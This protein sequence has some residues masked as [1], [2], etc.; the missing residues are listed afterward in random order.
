MRRFADQ[1]P[2][3]HKHDRA[4]QDQPVQEHRAGV[5]DAIVL[6]GGQHHHAPDRR[7]LVGAVEVLHEA[8]H[9]DYPQ[10]AIGI[11]LRHDRVLDLR[12]VRD[13]LDVK[14]GLKLE[15]LER[16]VGRQHRCGRYQFFG[17]QAL[18]HLAGA[19]RFIANLRHGHIRCGH[20]NR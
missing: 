20:Q 16:L 6:G 15:A 4:R 1:H 3:V 12:F 13:A 9:L 14:A 5:H 18:L 7:V 17:H 2:A 19:V 8:A 10:P 11:K